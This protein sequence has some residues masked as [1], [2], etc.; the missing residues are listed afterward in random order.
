MRAVY[1]EPVRTPMSFAE[2]AHAARWR[3]KI[4]LGV[5]PSDEILAL[6]LAKTA[7][8]TGR[9]SA[10]WGGNWGNWKATEEW[11]DQ[12]TCIVLNEVINGRLVWFAPEGQLSAAPNKGGVIVGPR[13]PVPDGHPQTRMRAFANNYDGIDVYVGSMARGRYRE[14]W[15]YLLKGVVALQKEFLARLRAE[16]PPPAVDLEW[17]RLKLVVPQLQFDVSELLQTPIGNDFVEAVA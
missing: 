7:L 2:A 15:G 9:W 4:E 13:Y 11:P 10:I 3:L 5:E 12:F 6:F 16:A 17:A 8:E 14:A 1:V